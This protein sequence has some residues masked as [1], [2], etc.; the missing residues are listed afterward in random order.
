MSFSMTANTQQKL[1]KAVLVISGNDVD[2][3]HC[4]I[5]FKV[6]VNI[7]TIPLNNSTKSHNDHFECTEP[8]QI[9]FVAPLM[10]FPNK[11][12]GCG[13]HIVIFTHRGQ[14]KIVFISK[15]GGTWMQWN[16]K[17]NVPMQLWQHWKLPSKCR[18]KLKCLSH[19]F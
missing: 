17:T 12:H 7:A 15:S 11:W 19:S 14:R 6:L 8:C 4:K 9:I 13:L 3:F 1:V 10:F 16:Q 18:G 2:C 5:Q